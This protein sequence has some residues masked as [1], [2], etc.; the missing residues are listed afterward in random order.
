MPVPASRPLSPQ[1]KYRS[2]AD[3]PHAGKPILIPRMAPN[4]DAIAAALQA[5][6]VSAV[7]AAGTG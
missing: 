1:Q 2:V 4:A 5:Y 6:N 7:S 3:S